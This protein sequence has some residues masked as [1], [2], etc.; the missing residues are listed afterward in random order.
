M[1]EQPKVRKYPFYKGKPVKR[2]R[3]GEHGIILT[4]WST[5]VKKPGRQ[6]TVS[7]ADWEKHGERRQLVTQSASDLRRM[8]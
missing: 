4:F 3:R 1:T 5:E 6:L 2:M 7:Q 8:A